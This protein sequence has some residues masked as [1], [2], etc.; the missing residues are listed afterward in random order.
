MQV[1]WVGKLT[2]EGMCEHLIELDNELKAKGIRETFRGRPW[3]DNCREWVYYDCILDL[4]K[5]RARYEFPFFVESHVNDD[6]K[7]GME[8]GFV[9]DLCKDGVIG[10]H[11]HFGKGKRIVE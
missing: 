11:P 7:S 9:C 1:F 4:E 3:S 10:L 2:I 8:A 5:I 6:N